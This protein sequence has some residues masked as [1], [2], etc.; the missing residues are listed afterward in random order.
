MLLKRRVD[1]V[2]FALVLVTIVWLPI[3]L[4]SNRPWAWSIFQ[5]M[6]IVQTCAVIWCYRS[7]IPWRQVKSI[8]PLLLPLILFQGFT[9]FQLVPLP[10][11]WLSALSPNSAK[12]YSI[13]NRDYA[14][15]TLDIHHTQLM[16]IL[17]FAYCCWVLNLSILIDRRSRLYALVLAIIVSG[18]IQAFYASMLALSDSSSSPIFGLPTQNGANGSFVYRNHLANYLLLCLS[19][20]IGLIVARMSHTGPERLS[21]AERMQRL[22]VVFMSDKMIVRLSLI[23]MVIALIMTRSRMGNTAFMMSTVM[24]TLIAFLFYKNKP[25]ALVVLIISIL[26]IDALLVGAIFGLDT[27]KE[28]I[29]KTVIASEARPEIVA[30]SLQAIGDHIWFGSGAGSFYSVF[31]AYHQQTITQFFDHAHNE[32]IQFLFQSG[33]L[34]TAILV[35]PVIYCLMLS[36]HTLRTRRSGMMKGLSLGCLM[37]MLA[38]LIHILVDF[39]LQPTANAVLFLTV[40][41]IVCICAKMPREGYQHFR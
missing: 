8:L 25:R 38:M 41:S 6:V 17:G 9:A 13:F 15:I 20:G 36:I 21:M 31:P 19:L 14:P 28:R 24:A 5:V 1:S 4:G 30:W 34:G 40:L 29:D 7:T 39:N 11:D 16:L 3:P 23:I 26:V 18:T 22:I 35:C 33:V 2:I 12:A 27:V 32:Y 10:L 37:A